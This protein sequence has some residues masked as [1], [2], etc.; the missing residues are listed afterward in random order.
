MHP[1]AYL[2]AC[3]LGQSTNGKQYQQNN[4]HISTC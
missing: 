4:A 3:R 1:Q 2:V